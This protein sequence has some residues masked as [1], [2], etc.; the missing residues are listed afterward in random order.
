MRLCGRAQFLVLFAAFLAVGLHVT[1][2]EARYDGTHRR[3][4]Y[5]QL[6]AHGAVKSASTTAS[7]LLNQ[8]EGARAGICGRGLRVIGT[9]AELSCDSLPGRR[10]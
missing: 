10:V 4:A 6:V 1:F 5:V 7:G 2:T 3:S 9:R 8:A